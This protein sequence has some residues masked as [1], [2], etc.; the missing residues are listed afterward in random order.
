MVAIKKTK[1]HPTA[2]FEKE[3]SILSQNSTWPESTEEWRF[4][5]Y[6]IATTYKTCPGDPKRITHICVIINEHNHNQLEICNSCGERYIGIF[7]SGI[8]ENDVRRLK[9]NIKLSM[10]EASLDYLRDKNAISTY[11]Y[12]GYKVVKGVR[13]NSYVLDFRKDINRKFLALTDYNNKSVLDTI[14]LILVWIHQNPQSDI[15]IK[16]LFDVRNNLLT[17]NISS[18]DLLES[19]IIGNKIDEIKYSQTERTNA[20]KV[21]DQYLNVWKSKYDKLFEYFSMD[22]QTGTFKAVPI[23]IRKKKEFD[24]AIHTLDLEYI[25]KYFKK[26]T[27]KREPLPEGMV[28]NK[29]GVLTYNLDLEPDTVN[30]QNVEILDKQRSEEHAEIS[31]IL[32]EPDI[33]NKGEIQDTDQDQVSAIEIIETEQ[34]E[35]DLIDDFEI[36][37]TPEVSNCD[38]SEPIKYMDDEGS[39]YNSVYEK[40][41]EEELEYE[42]SNFRDLFSVNGDTTTSEIIDSNTIQKI[43]EFILEHWEGLSHDTP[44]DDII[45]KFCTL[46]DKLLD[47]GTNVFGV[48]W[49]ENVNILPTITS[50]HD[51]LSQLPFCAVESILGSL[52][53]EHTNS[54]KEPITNVSKITLIQKLNKILSVE[55]M[56]IICNGESYPLDYRN[57]DILQEP[58]L[59]YYIQQEFRKNEIK[60]I[61]GGNIK[62]MVSESLNFEDF[63]DYF[64]Q[65]MV[66]LTESDSFMAILS[67]INEGSLWAIY[68]CDRRRDSFRRIFD[69]VTVEVFDKVLMR[70]FRMYPDEITTRVEQLNNFFGDDCALKYDPKRECT[71]FERTENKNKKVEIVEVQATLPVDDEIEPKPMDNIRTFDYLL[72]S[73]DDSKAKVKE[74]SVNPEIERQWIESC[75]QSIEQSK[76]Y[77]RDLNKLEEETNIMILDSISQRSLLRLE[78]FVSKYLKQ[79]TSSNSIQVFVLTFDH[80]E[81]TDVYDTNPNISNL[82]DF[83]SK[84]SLGC[85]KSVITQLLSQ[86]LN[87][88]KV[89]ISDI[90][91]NSMVLELEDIL[92]EE[93]LVLKYTG[94]AKPIQHFFW[95]IEPK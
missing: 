57:W 84:L 62:W 35:D 32:E 56:I 76:Q 63:F 26:E 85:I 94:Y 14:D 91:K 49:D 6:Y 53:S 77:A 74:E 39:E 48:F 45:T 31:V 3:L 50:L 61:Q 55:R 75:N 15:D 42:Q 67:F 54:T 37:I 36:D 9:A 66:T 58:D 95:R 87:K 78:S 21:F 10:S 18:T 73:N 8:I 64:N 22:P 5:A 38:Y 80:I 59:D 83:M 11:E 23:E 72:A 19:I 44:I 28:R 12:D 90:F 65:W 16:A 40:K 2:G 30:E 41:E 93:N 4:L 34:Y 13:S 71:F 82:Y 60:D 86:R 79:L 7:E 46:F 88:L 68:D 51:L 24:P 70:L 92:S 25:S 33:Y 1:E 20:Y 89:G 27:R 81:I 47:R 29:R 52:L 69:F 43:A 17:T